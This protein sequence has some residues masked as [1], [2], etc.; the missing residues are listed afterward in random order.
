VTAYI[1]RYR[2]LL[3]VIIIA[4][5]IAQVNCKEKKPITSAATKG[6]TLW[7]APDSNHIPST[8]EGEL[9][10]Y[11]RKLISNTAFYL[12]PKGTVA[13]ITNG[14]N[15]Q[16]C[17]L[18]AG[19]RLYGN[20]Y[21]AVFS[22]Y[23]KFR[24]RSGAIENIYK[25]VNDC[26]QRSLNG[27]QI[28]TNSHEMRAIEAYIRWL[29]QSVPKNV[30]PIGSGIRDLPF[31]NRAADT[32]MGSMVYIK[33]CRLCHGNSGQGVLNADSTA[34]IYPPLWGEHSYTVSAGLYRISRF[35]GYVKDNMPFGTSY[36]APQLTN[37][38]AWDVAAFINS[39]PR[40]QKV[41]KKD[42]PNISGKPIDHPFGPYAD[43][44]SERQH[45]YGPFG[46]MLRQ[47]LK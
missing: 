47:N 15:C 30:K 26:L 20:N 16:N 40:P 2:Q 33:K 4:C 28:D 13:P 35:A 37:E 39:Q 45:K 21:S 22:T 8:P 23:P 10:S 27:K 5:T 44:F 42:W 36:L 7:R 38:E 18:D 6:D 31:M 43:S 17:H 41:F 11:G 9:I 32:V 1:K 24:A 46:R 14:M 29:G 12:G 3:C 34:Y 25:R 19:T